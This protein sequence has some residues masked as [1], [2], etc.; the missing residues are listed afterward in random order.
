MIYKGLCGAK[1]RRIYIKDRI[2]LYACEW[3]EVVG[4]SVRKN[5]SPKVIQNE[6][7]EWC[8]QMHKRE[9]EKL[10][11]VRDIM[12]APTITEITVNG[13]S[14]KVPEYEKEVND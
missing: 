9:I 7:R 6:L 3:G 12:N 1:W 2:P 8:K 13:E 10:K 11:Y 5:T 14:K 4:I